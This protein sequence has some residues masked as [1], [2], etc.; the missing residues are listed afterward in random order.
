MQEMEEVLAAQSLYHL[1]QACNWIKVMEICKEWPRICGRSI[2]RSK[3]TA[4]HLAVNDGQEKTVEELVGALKDNTPLRETNE[5]GDTPL[6][7]AAARGSQ[8]MC[9]TMARR[10]SG[11]IQLRNNKGETPFYLAALHGNVPAFLSLHA[12]IKDNTDIA[13]CRRIVDGDTILHC[14]IRRDYFGTCIFLC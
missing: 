12:T 14:T 2:T 8:K 9:A 3:D 7:C 4:L 1:T 10:D 13:L 11:L 5:R 6:H